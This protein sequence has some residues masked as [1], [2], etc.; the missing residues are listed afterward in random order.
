MAEN[1]RV[2]KSV[3][4]SVRA[5]YNKGRFTQSVGLNVATTLR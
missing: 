5:V 1:R 2:G 3:L 4:K